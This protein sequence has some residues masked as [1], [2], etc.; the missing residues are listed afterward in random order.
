MKILYLYSEI[1]GYQ[2]PILEEYVNKYDAEVHVVHWNNKKLSN[3]IIPSIEG[4]KFYNRSDFSTIKL[5]KFV[6]NLNPDIIYISGW[7]DFS[8]LAAVIPMRLNNI[9]VVTAF[10]D[11]WFNTFKQRLASLLFPIFR[12]YLYSHAWVAGPYQYEFAKRLKFKNY[13]IVFNCL[14]ANLSMFNKVYLDSS[15][16]KR[17]KFPHKFLYVGRLETEKG[18]DILAKAWQNLCNRNL[19]KD[20]EMTFIGNG[21]LH[22]YLNNFKSVELLDFLQ[23]EELVVEIKKY[24]CFILPSR[25]EQWGLVLH[26]FTAAGF[27][28]ICSDICGA[29]PVFITNGLNGNTFKSG[30]IIDLEKQILKIINM[31]DLSLINMS[32]ISNQLGQK[33]SPEITAASFISI[34]K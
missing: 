4:V 11:I 21:S 10:D 31:S 34:L 19:T 15:N 18:V 29:S 7:M 27:P 1:I 3:Y 25:K 2:M 30:D 32:K 14:S 13:N 24:G 16:N 20:W 12:K 26:E 23:P 5:I 17:N 8:Y 33:I 22:E 28:V 6:K 9:P